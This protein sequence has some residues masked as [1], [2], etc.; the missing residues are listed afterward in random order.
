VH[1]LRRFG[2]VPVASAVT[3]VS[4]VCTVLIGFSRCVDLIAPCSSTAAL[5]R[6][7]MI[8]VPFRQLRGTPGLC[9]A[10]GIVW[11]MAVISDSALYSALVSEVAVDKA[12]C[13]N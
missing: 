13:V 8:L 9:L 7:Y 3:V 11:G 10:I 4:A 2:R 12:V 5:Q 1:V 6:L